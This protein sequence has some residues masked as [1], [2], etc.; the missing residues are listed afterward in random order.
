MKKILTFFRYFFL[1]GCLAFGL[2]FITTL[3]IHL[4][5]SPYTIE[6]VLGGAMGCGLGTGLIVGIQSTS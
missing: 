2:M 5:W 6:S 4:L 3:F 1:A